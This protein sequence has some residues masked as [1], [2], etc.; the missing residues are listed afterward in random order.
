MRAVVGVIMS[1]TSV[2]RRAAEG[3]SDRGVEEEEEDQQEEEE[4][5]SRGP[6]PA[7]KR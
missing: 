5:I 6:A 4:E 1:P 3:G 2:P 7:P